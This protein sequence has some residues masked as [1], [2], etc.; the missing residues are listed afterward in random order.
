MEGLRRQQRIVEPS[1]NFFFCANRSF[2]GGVRSES[3]YTTF[4]YFRQASTAPCNTGR[5]GMIV[6]CPGF[7]VLA[8]VMNA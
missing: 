4:A 6:S 2:G 8:R 5:R 7:A 3:T 1:P